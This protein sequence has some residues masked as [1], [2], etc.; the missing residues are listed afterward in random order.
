MTYIKQHGLVERFRG[1]E[2]LASSSD[3]PRLL[4]APDATAAN[5]RYYLYFCCSDDSE[6]FATSDSPKGPFTNPVRLPAT[7]IDPAIFIDRDGQA[8]YF[9]GQFNASGA[10]LTPSMSGIEEST[11]VHALL[12]EDN[13][14]FHEGSP[15]WRFGNVYYFVFAD[16]SRGKPTCLGYATSTSPLG[17]FTYRGVII[18]NAEADPYSWNNHGSIEQV[19]GPR[20][21]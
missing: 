9:W 10:K 6:G 4:F 18:N 15:M 1:F 14:D 16:N 13:P 8:Y 7:G 19:N 12:T 5:G 3:P 2:E 11:V 17:P 21:L 20:S